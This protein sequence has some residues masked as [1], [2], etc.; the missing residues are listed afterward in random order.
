[1]KDNFLFDNAPDMM[2]ILAIGGKFIDCNQ[3]C[4]NILGYTKDEFLSM[5]SCYNIFAPNSASKALIAREYMQQGKSF[6]NLEIRLI[7]KD[8]T[9]LDVL[10]NLA[11]IEDKENNCLRTFA[12]WRESTELTQARKKLEQHNKSLS[13]F[14]HAISHDLSA[15][16]RGISFISQ[17]LHKELNRDIK[18][19][20]KEAWASLFKRIEHLN[21]YFHDIRTYLIGN[22][23]ALKEKVNTLDLVENILT[24]LVK[25]KGFCVFVAPDMPVFDTL[26]IHLQQVFYNLIANAITHHPTPTNATLLITVEE[27]DDLYHFSI[28]DNGPTLSRADKKEII[29]HL[30]FPTEVKT[31]GMG[32][33]IVKRILD[34]VGGT[35]SICSENQHSNTFT[36]TWPKNI[37]EISNSNI[38]I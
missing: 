24:L 2:A 32:L 14:A 12:V 19:A 34:Q 10:C 38:V 27:Q 17:L 28:I 36:F 22:K 21:S 18:E 33:S 30:N 25:P 1:M 5:E 9:E 6:K 23:C 16:L 20:S 13:L 31:S 3:E 29:Q 7:K 26:R 15:P 35:F 37:M 4:T 11:A 8:K